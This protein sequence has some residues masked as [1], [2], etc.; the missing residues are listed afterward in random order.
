MS[1]GEIIDSLECEEGPCGKI[2]EVLDELRRLRAEN[3]D[4][5]RQNLLQS[6]EIRLMKLRKYGQS[7]EKLT[8]E[9]IS[10][11]KLFD[12][13]ELYSTAN[14]DSTATEEVR[15]TKTVYTRRKRGRKPL[16]PKLS[17]I[18]VVVDLSDEEK[19][20]AEGFELIQ[21]GEEVSEQVHEVPQK[22]IV[23]RTV[24]PKYVVRRVGGRSVD[25]ESTT[26]EMPMTVIK[27]APLPPRI[28]PRSIATPS[29]LSAV[30]TAKFCDGLP[31][32][33]QERMFARHG[34][35]ISRQDMA[36]WAI[37]VAKRLE[38]LI[39][40]MKSELLGSPYLHCDE[41]FFQ[42]M[43]EPSKANTTQSYMWVTTG[44]VGETRVVLYQYSRTRNAEFIKTFLEKYSGYLQTDGYDGYTAIGEKDGIVHVGCWAHARRKFVEAQKI[45]E[46][47]GSAPQ[48]LALIGELYEV[49]RTLRS[50]YF[51]SGCS[52][53]LDAFAS[54]RKDAILPI[55]Q[56]IDAWLTAKEIEVTP[57]SALGKAVSY[58]RDL[59]PRLVRYLECPHLTPDNNEAERAIRPFTIGRK[60]W[61]ISGGPRGAFA[62]ATLYS[63]IE[64]AKLCSLE[65][66]YYLRYVLSKLP[67]TEPDK[68]WSLLPW[69][70]D[71]NVF[72]ELTAE[73][74][75]IS[76]DS[77][78]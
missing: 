24:R 68:I 69:N 61:V 63:F 72:G 34:L 48:I 17:R 23:I 38:S 15:I 27:V 22:Y 77:I 16:S 54:E 71:T 37:A 12:E 11:G 40:L 2:E 1:E 56:K 74:A 51:A 43:D 5:K 75:R 36:N 73:D 39:E 55:F 67:L 21:I 65:P 52:G 41:T 20:V 66:Y 13:A 70:I 28:L 57:Q 44:G 18:E 14:D 29:L 33:R 53:D 9:D 4:L 60:N 30:L 7:S 64:T 8:A 10:Q 46:G 78:P 35:V 59:W 25:D 19:T 3:T 26:E 6:E 47:K 42:V 62:S 31:F 58:T 49:E 45:T 32:Y 50:K 76:L